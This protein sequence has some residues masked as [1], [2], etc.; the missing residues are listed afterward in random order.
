MKK[1]ILASLLAMCCVA[2][3]TACGGNETPAGNDA[4]NASEPAGKATTEVSDSTEATEDQAGDVSADAQQSTYLLPD[5]L[6]NPNLVIV[7]DKTEEAWNQ[8]LTDDPA[9][10]DLVWTTKEAFESKYG[11]EV[12]VIGVAWGDMMNQTISMVNTGEVCDLVQAHDQNFP[13]YGAKNI[14]QD[15]SQ[16]VD[17]NDDFWYDS[18]TSTFT[19]GGTPYA[20]GS[21]ATPVVISYNK[22]LF[23]QN[24]VKTPMEYFKEGN[25]TW[26][27]FREVALQMTA[28][29]D[30]DGT[31]DIYGFGWWDSFYVQMLN[32]NGTTTLKFGEDGTIGSNYLSAEATEAFTFLQNA[33]MTDKFIMHP[34]GDS[35]INDFKSGKLA[36]TCEYGFAAITAYA[37]D[38]EIEWAPLPIGPSGEQYACGGSLT[39]FAVPTTSENPEGAV[40]FAR[41]AYEMLHEHNNK[42]RVEKYG[43]EEVDLMNTLAQHINFSPI[44]IEKYWDANWT[45]FS[46]L[47][48]GT[49]V[50]TFA[51]TA[52]EQIKEGAAITLGAE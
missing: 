35:F 12:E 29:T 20:I 32:A 41:M 48:D 5:S 8:T 36:M 22:T 40:V 24:G 2:S 19:F 43:E 39:G 42:A 1:R 14:V 38:Y 10:F 44:G 26:D 18:V 16:Y 49:P 51:T 3:F 7:W 15:I 50:N 37:C 6:E 34:D 46:G 52:D 27:T 4:T 45:I 9:A 17:L 21:D 30:G 28:D 11:G 47:T 23:E 33:Y 13:I 25:W 31:N